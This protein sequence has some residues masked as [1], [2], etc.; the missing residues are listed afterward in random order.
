VRD[1]TFRNFNVECARPLRFVGNH[2]SILKN[3][4]L[5]NFTAEVECPGSPSVIY[6]TC[7]R[8]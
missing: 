7:G 4:R 3:I 6:W 8:F 1:V 2:D 5:E